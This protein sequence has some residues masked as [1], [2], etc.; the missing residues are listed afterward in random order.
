MALPV[1]VHNAGG[2]YTPAEIIAELRR[3]LVMRERVYPA[4]VAA[5]RMKLSD[6]RTQIAI[7]SSIL[8]DYVVLYGN[9]DRE[10]ELFT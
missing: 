5:G 7:L 10:P 2:P 6:A 4:R 9:C 3:E 8:A 1:L